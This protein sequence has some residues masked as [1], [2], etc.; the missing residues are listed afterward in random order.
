MSFCLDDVNIGG[1]LHLGYGVYDAIKEGKNKI[2]GTEA[3]DNLWAQYDAAEHAIGRASKKDISP[4]DVIPSIYP[5][6]YDTVHLNIGPYS[7]AKDYKHF[8]N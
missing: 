8:F 5:E 6:W 2:N 1:Q 7:M 4:S 3:E